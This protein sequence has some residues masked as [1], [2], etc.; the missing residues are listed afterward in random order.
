MDIIENPTIAKPEKI[1]SMTRANEQTKKG[2]SHSA[3]GKDVVLHVD[4]I[5]TTDTGGGY[6][7]SSSLISPSGQIPAAG[8]M[9]RSQGGGYKVYR[10]R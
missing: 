5:I 7:I 3:Y 9:I 8:M 6:S 10:E 4:F 2:S 1:T